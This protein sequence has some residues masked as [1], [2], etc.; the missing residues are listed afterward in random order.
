MANLTQQTSSGLVWSTIQRFAVMAVT[1]ISNVILARILAP[2]DFGCVAMLMIFIGLANTFIDGG[3]GSA[4]IQKKEPTQIDYSTIFYWNLVLS[5]VLYVIIFL[6]APLVARFYR[7]DLLTSVLRVQGVVL[8]L[9][10]LSI[11]QQ[12][13]LQKELRFK[14]LAIVNIISSV[15]SLI[16]AILAALSGWGVW[17]L[18]VQQLS[19]SAFIAISVF[20]ATR[21]KPLWAFSY[22]SF[23]SLFKFGGFILLSNLFSTIANEIQGLLVGRSFSSATLGLYN[24]AYRLEGSAANTVSSVMN[25]VTYPVLASLQDDKQK[26][27]S[28]L[29][30]FIQV[31]A[32]VC[33][34]IMTFVIVAAKPIIVL[35]YTE[36]WIE[37]YPYLQVLCLAGLAACLQG[38]ANQAITAI[39]KSNVFFHW[40]IVKRALTII[41]S[42]IGIAMWGMNG[43]LWGCVVGTWAVY[44]INGYL[45]QKYIGYPLY[46]QFLVI[47]PYILLSV[48][49]G[50]GALYM[51]NHLALH[52]YW[53]AVIQFVFISVLYLGLSWLLKLDS[54]IYVYGV[55]KNRFA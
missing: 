37:C 42:I 43:L 24:Q 23:S 5:V 14:T 29:K 32:F 3:F 36:K 2:D 52:M 21:W 38:S 31:P 34:P 44:I 1:F 48:I 40:T 10:A 35:I 50:Y 28:A 8:L 45:V 25:Q 27:Q 6:G 11:I 55:L 12:N 4:L 7:I 16:V 13:K 47:L 18:V 20:I 15:L 49:V 53:I 54:L 39:G 46:Q 51:G 26:M 17:S 22:E 19:L 41:L 30:R 9:N 33:C